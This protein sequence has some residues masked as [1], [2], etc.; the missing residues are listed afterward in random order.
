ME[1]T[2]KALGVPPSRKF[3][4]GSDFYTLPVVY[5][6]AT[7]QYIG[8][9]WDI[10]LYLDCKYPAGP[11]LVPQGMAGVTKAWNDR[12]DQLFTS[13]VRLLAHG[14][15]FNPENADTSRQ[16][17]VSRGQSFFI[18]ATGR[19][20]TWDDCTAKG[21]ERR[22]MLDDF[23]S[24]LGELEQ[25]YS[26]PEQHGTQCRAQGG[27]GLFLAGDEPTYADLIVGGW[28]GYVHETLPPSELA[29]FQ[30]WHNGRWTKIWLALAKYADTGR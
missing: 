25:Y 27:G 3:P 15:P 6:S 26:F 12:V 16:I 4:D 22:Q 18:R 21:E 30:A 28:L 29:E 7:D 20:M 1:S 8:D 2:R 24:A 13:F 10:A 19:Q 5:D 14:T 9:S 23:R 17:L 11:R